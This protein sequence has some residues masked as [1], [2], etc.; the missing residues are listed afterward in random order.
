VTDTGTGIDPGILQ[1]I[2]EPFFTTKEP[3]KGTGLGLSTVYGIVRQNGGFINVDS[4]PGRG[5]TFK[6]YL[7]LADAGVRGAETSSEGSQSLR[8][9]ETVLVVEDQGDVCELVVRTLRSYGYSVFRA[10]NGNEALLI[11]NERSEPIHLLL[12][13]VVMP[14]INGKALA[15]SLKRSRPETKVLY[16]S[17]YMENAIVR[18]NVL[19]S[20]AAYIPKPFAPEALAAKVREVLNTHPSRTIS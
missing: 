7:P 6:V 16:M 4:E 5:T 11:A 14:G 3:G 10:A 19:D 8:G 15:E 13:D 1:F 17:G 12:T 9:S 18:Q 20:D 2:F